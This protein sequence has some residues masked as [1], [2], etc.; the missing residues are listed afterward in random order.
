MASLVTLALAGL[1]DGPIPS[2]A[3]VASAATATSA[4]WRPTT[5]VPDFVGLV[6]VPVAATASSQASIPES[7][8]LPAVS[9]APDST[10]SG[11]PQ[12]GPH[13][14]Y[15]VGFGL[16]VS[17][18]RWSY[19]PG[20]NCSNPV[21]PPPGVFLDPCLPGYWFVSHNWSL[22]GRFFS[23]SI[24]SQVDYWDGAGVEHVW[25][26][27]SRRIVNGGLPAAQGTATF[28]TCAAATGP[29]FLLVGAS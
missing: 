29:P 7:L 11:P 25:H 8:V 23:A 1:G 28:Q 27:G 4:H 18:G 24:G 15:L 16:A 14:N 22:G 6:N 3:T 21:A 26:V 10:S 20:H 13:R 5:A 9:S 17:V 19:A 2:S 12:A